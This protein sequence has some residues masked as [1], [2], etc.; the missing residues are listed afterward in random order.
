MLCWNA[1]RVVGSGQ[2]S[3][4]PT[5]G[6][7]IGCTAQGRL[8]LNESSRGDVRHCQTASSLRK[9]PPLSFREPLKCLWEARKTRGSVHE[10]THAVRMALRAEPSAG[11]FDRL[12]P[13]ERRNNSARVTQVAGSQR[14]T[15][16]LLMNQGREG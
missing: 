7:S 13:G 16:H 8:G 11:S 14:R 9:Q 6:L 4:S 3:V 12:Q 10:L 1:P 15:S 2:T 5:A